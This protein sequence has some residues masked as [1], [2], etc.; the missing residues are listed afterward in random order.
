MFN[1]KR[2]LLVKKMV[3]QKRFSLGII[4]LYLILFT[5]N[6]QATIAL[7]N[8]I[9]TFNDPKK[10]REDIEIRNTSQ[11][12]V[13]IQ[14]TPHIIK[15]PGTPQQ[16][17]L[18]YT[19][20]RQAGLL[21]TPNKLIIPAGK[22]RRIRFVNLNPRRTEEG[23]YRVTVSPIAA[24]L[25]IQQQNKQLIT[26]LKIIVAYEVLV[27]VQPI[28]AKENLM[29]TRTANKIIFQNK[30]N[31]NINLRFGKQCPKNKPTSD[32]CKQL[33]GKRL[34]PNNKFIQTLPYDNTI[35]YYIN[36]AGENIIR[37]YP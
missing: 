31:I 15:N 5:L 25:K 20:P 3:S 27:L 22:K 26:G 8:V 30:G 14:V 6:V 10:L 29:V 18:T 33:L 28:K 12:T 24:P 7:S 13:Y 32:Q 16:E 19:N 1:N 37:H 36:I 17:R 21:V 35:D 2:S 9:I 34:Y 4:S 23:I 11:E